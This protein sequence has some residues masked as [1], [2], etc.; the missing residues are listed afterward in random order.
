[1]VHR[2]TCFYGQVNFKVPPDRDT[3]PCIWLLGTNLA[4]QLLLWCP[5]HS[6]G[7][8]MELPKTS[9]WHRRNTD[10][11]FP[12]CR[13]LGSLPLWQFRAT[14]TNSYKNKVSTR[15][16]FESVHSHSFVESRHLSR[17]CH[18]HLYRKINSKYDYVN[19]FILNY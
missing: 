12:N 13:G 10:G 5:H 7:G 11:A 4:L 19:V 3:L 15:P 18:S 17:D 14:H 6:S 8:E 16:L 9:W 1:M 2:I